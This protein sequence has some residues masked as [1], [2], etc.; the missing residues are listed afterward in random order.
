M[1][2]IAVCRIVIGALLLEGGD[3][4]KDYGQWKCVAWEGGA[5]SKLRVTLHGEDQSGGLT[6]RDAD[7]QLTDAGWRLNKRMLPSPKATAVQ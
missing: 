6:T 1:R 5:R 4:G 3:K 2:G 7:L